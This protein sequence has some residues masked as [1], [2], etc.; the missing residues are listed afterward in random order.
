MKARISAKQECLLSAPAFEA[1]TAPAE[2]GEKAIAWK[3][4]TLP[5]ELLPHS[6]ATRKFY[7]NTDEITSCCRA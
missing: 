1:K 7:A 6:C 3:A 2:R 4:G 5:T